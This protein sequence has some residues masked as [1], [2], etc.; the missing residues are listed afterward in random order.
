ICKLTK[1]VHSVIIIWYQLDSLGQFANG[2]YCGNETA[3][4]KAMMR[5]FMVESI[6]YWVNE[7][8]LDGFR[9]DLM[10]LHDA[11]TMDSIAKAVK[12][13]DPSIFIY[14]EGWV[15][16][17]SPLP[18]NQQANKYNLDQFEMVAAFSDDI[19]DAI[20]GHV[21]T[22]NETGF[23][24]GKTGLAESVKFGIIASTQHPQVDYAKVNYSDA[25]W[26]P[27][28]LRTITYTSCHD[29]FTI[30]DK[31]SLALPDAN[32][33]EKMKMQKLALSMVLTSQG[34]PFLHAGSEMA[35]TKQ[36]VE[37]SFESPDEINQ[38]DWSV[39]KEQMDLVNYVQQLIALRKAHPAF[40]MTT[41]EDIQKHLE[42]LPG[43][44]LLVA[45]QLKDNANGDE[46]KDIIVAFNGSTE[47]KE[48]ALENGEWNQVIRGEHFVN[49]NVKVSDGKIM[50][51]ARGALIVT[52]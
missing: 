40:R 48:V 43:D 30:W 12:A 24:G 6:E 15:A 20:K 21:F 2:S 46:W 52:R 36:G 11:V 38:I 28:P 37:N 9:F 22:A 50:V 26:A 19:R 1:A 5:K 10:G 31:L 44:D 13:I 7:Y 16:G 45:Y 14:G 23:V 33:A 39:K 49:Q 8:H 4:D 51:P 35:R 32:E 3:S 34:I 29:N 47:E 27:N 17:D 42:F 41:T 18:Q 25:A